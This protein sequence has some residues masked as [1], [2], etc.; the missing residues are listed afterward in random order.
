MAFGLAEIIFLIETFLM[1]LSQDRKKK[2][3]KV[4]N[5]VIYYKS[6]NVKKKKDLH[7]DV[8]NLTFRTGLRRNP[9][10]Q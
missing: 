5:I 2:T 8:I 10:V 7:W 3:F 6:L 4:I 9:D 1:Y